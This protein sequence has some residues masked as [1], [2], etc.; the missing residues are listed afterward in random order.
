LQNT[1]R[2]SLASVRGSDAEWVFAGD[3]GIPPEGME[4]E[5]TVLREH[6][7]LPGGFKNVIQNGQT[8]G[9]QV[10]VRTAYYRGVYLTLVEGFEVEVDG[11]T[12]HKD[13]IT[14]TV[15]GKPYTFDQLAK[16]TDG[17]WPYREPAVLS[18]NKP[19]GLKRGMHDLVVTQHLR[20]SY[21]PV[22]AQ[23]YVSKRKV[24]LVI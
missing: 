14:F 4:K 18:V 12:F 10:A 19:G 1:L 5:T 9:F 17:R 7:I 11:E 16:T 20:I 2:R 15:G 6:L 23:T 22:T 21:M 13:R 3:S 24:A 8:T